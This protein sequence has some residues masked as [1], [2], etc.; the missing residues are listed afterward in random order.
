MSV[1]LA[2]EKSGSRLRVISDSLHRWRN[3]FSGEPWQ[4][5]FTFLESLNDTSPV[6]EYI[7][8]DGPRLFA[9]VM[10]YPTRNPDAAILE[11]HDKFIDIQMSL[12]NAERIEWYR[13]ERLRTRKPYDE[14]T[15]V[16]LFNRPEIPCGTIHNVPGVFSVFFPDD[17]HMAQLPVPGYPEHVKKVVV[18]V[19]TELL[20][21]SQ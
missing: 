14:K 9:R 13:R 15:D 10:A 3:Y 4:T 12:E 17:A 2:P 18:K 5:A 11:A 19:H 8:M 21:R 6:A 1:P 20:E 7:E 16:V